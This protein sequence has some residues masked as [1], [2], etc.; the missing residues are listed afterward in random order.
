MSNSENTNYTPAITSD[1]AEKI[2]WWLAK[3]PENQRQSAVIP[4]LHILQE[5]NSG[6]LTNEIMDELAEYLDMPKIAVYEVATFYGMYE[7]KPVG[8]H[9][10]NI[11]T[12]ISCMLRG[13][14]EI[15]KHLENK[16]DVKLGGTTADGKFTLKPVECQ[17]ACCGAPMLETGKKFYENLTV[18]KVDKLLQDLG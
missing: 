10:L 6:Y 12:N 1:V 3:F 11:C 15:V 5:K 17:G 13:S 8:K 4:G 2:E 9:M 14:K 18:E 7:H 16:L